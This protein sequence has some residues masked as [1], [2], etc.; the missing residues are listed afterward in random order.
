MTQEWDKIEPIWFC[1][2]LPESGWRRVVDL[3][4]N[5]IGVEMRS[6]YLVWTALAERIVER[7]PVRRVLEKE[8]LPTVVG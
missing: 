6:L 5:V 7:R 8:E 4:G 1:E 2:G 3:W